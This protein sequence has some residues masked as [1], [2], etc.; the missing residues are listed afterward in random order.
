MARGPT[1]IADVH[2]PFPR[3]IDHGV[4]VLQVVDDAP[5]GQALKSHAVDAQRRQAIELQSS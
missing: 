5:A 1:S 4:V 2:G 3:P